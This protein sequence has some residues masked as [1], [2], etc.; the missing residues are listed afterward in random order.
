MAAPPPHRYSSDI[1]KTPMQNPCRILLA[2]MSL[3][4]GFAGCSQ[5]SPGP[6]AAPPVAVSAPAP[7][8]ATVEKPSMPTDPAATSDTS[9]EK[10][11]KPEET[12]KTELTP[13]QFNVLRKKGTERAFTGEYWDNHAPG[14][15][16]CAGC[17]LPLYDASTKFDSG[18]GWPSFWKAIGTKN[19]DTEVDRGGF[20]VRTELHCARCGG[21]LGHVFDD[22]PPPSGMRHCINSV[23]LKFVPAKKDD[24]APKSETK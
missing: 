10:V 15:Y 4:L 12:W 11:V 17:G 23:S 21:H 2:V 1:G 18:T 24:A 19:V 13:T 8:P 6:T 22:G 20:G 9:T 14:V 7:S 5:E 3:S 16:V